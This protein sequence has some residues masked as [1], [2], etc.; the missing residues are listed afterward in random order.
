M[1]DVAWVG[2]GICGKTPLEWFEQE[3]N[4]SPVFYFLDFF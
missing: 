3:G 2:R 4:G 1:Q